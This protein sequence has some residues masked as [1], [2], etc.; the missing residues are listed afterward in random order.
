MI[1][2]EAPSQSPAH[3]WPGSPRQRSILDQVRC[4]FRGGSNP[5]FF[6]ARKSQKESA[7]RVLHWGAYSPRRT[8]QEMGLWLQEYFSPLSLHALSHGLSSPRQWSIVDQG[9]CF[10]GSNPLFCGA[11][12]S[13]QFFACYNGGRVAQDARGESSRNGL[14]ASGIA[15]SRS[16]RTVEPWSQQVGCYLILAG[17]GVDEHVRGLASSITFQPV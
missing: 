9:R 11:R 5:L 15:F 7:L 12:K 4:L 10:G 14:A 13:N 2:S 8:D 17:E 1:H 6:H 3:P 16:L